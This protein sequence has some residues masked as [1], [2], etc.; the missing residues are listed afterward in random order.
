MTCFPD[1]NTIAKL[2]IEQGIKLGGEGW[3]HYLDRREIWTLKRPV[4]LTALLEPLFEI[5]QPLVDL[6]L[7]E[8]KVKNSII[9][10]L[11]NIFQVIY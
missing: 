5:L 2:F 3:A 7:K 11:L 9:I 4:W 6:L 8:I 1:T 10:I